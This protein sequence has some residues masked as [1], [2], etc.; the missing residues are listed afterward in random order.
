MSGFLKVILILPYIMPILNEHSQNG[1]VSTS[2]SPH[3][4]HVEILCLLIILII[5]M[6]R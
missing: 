6:M 1:R 5:D 4:H 3:L 2:I